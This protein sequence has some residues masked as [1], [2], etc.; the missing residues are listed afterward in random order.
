MPPSCCVSV[1]ASLQPGWVGSPVIP[2]QGGVAAFAAAT[3]VQ[4]SCV[5]G[6][7][8]AGLCECGRCVQSLQ[9]H[10]VRSKKGDPHLR[11]GP[12]WRLVWSLQ[13]GLLQFPVWEQPTRLAAVLPGC[14]KDNLYELDWKRR[15]I[16]TYIYPVWLESFCPLFLSL[17][18]PLSEV[19]MIFLP[20]PLP[21]F[22]SWC[23]SHFKPKV[24]LTLTY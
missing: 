11:I 1:L 6:C 9:S 8:C 21:F 15:K 17:T 10:L 16:T 12:G 22:R 3:C 2:I 18:A 7:A 20:S 4:R 19:W 24:V 13:L 23:K 14:L 5:C